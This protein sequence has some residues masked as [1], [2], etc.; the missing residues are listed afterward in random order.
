MKIVNSLYFFLNACPDR[1]VKA[2]LRFTTKFGPQSKFEMSTMSS[3]YINF[4]DIFAYSI[5]NEPI[6]VKFIFF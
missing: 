2:Y 3:K 4:V 1:P 6:V 5:S